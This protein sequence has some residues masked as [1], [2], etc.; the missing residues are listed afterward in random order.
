MSRWSTCVG[1]AGGVVVEGSGG[2]TDAGGD[3]EVAG[4]GGEAAVACLPP[5]T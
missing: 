3:K 1:S 5:V 2:K 4:E